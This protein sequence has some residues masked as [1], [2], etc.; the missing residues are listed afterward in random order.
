MSES[1]NPDIPKVSQEFSKRFVIKHIESS[2]SRSSAALKNTSVC[3]ESLSRS[4]EEERV[5]RLESEK[6]LDK[7]NS[8]TNCLAVVAIVCSIIQAVSSVVALFV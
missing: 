5:Q 3:I 2:L 1:K 4:L 7:Q 6:K 8:F